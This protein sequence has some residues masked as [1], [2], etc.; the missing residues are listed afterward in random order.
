M[1]SASTRRRDDDGGCRDRRG[2]A[3]RRHHD[4]SVPVLTKD[5]RD[6]RRNQRR[7]S[8]LAPVQKVVFGITR[9]LSALRA[10]EE[11][12][13]KAFHVNATNMA[14]TEITTFEDINDQVTAQRTLTAQHEALKRPTGS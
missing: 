11:R 1:C 4:L 6:S 2:H 14:I 9:D 10:S 7:Q 8:A 12:F 13:K 5:G 3:G